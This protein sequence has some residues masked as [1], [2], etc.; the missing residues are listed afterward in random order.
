M[1]NQLHSGGGRFA[2]DGELENI[3]EQ[4]SYKASVVSQ[5]RTLTHEQIDNL[6]LSENLNEVQEQV[7]EELFG[8]TRAKL[9]GAGAKLGAQAGN[10][11][12]KVTTGA[13]NL[14]AKAGQMA[15]NVGNA[16]MG[17]QDQLAPVADAGNAEAQQ[18]DPQAAANAAKLQSI[19]PQLVKTL[20]KANQSLAGDLEALGL[21]FQ[22]IAQVDPE[23]AKSIKYA[24]GWITKAIQDLNSASQGVQQQA[25]PQQ[26][27]PAQQAPAMQYNSGAAM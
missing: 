22:T 2:R 16:A 7:I 25:D 11:A 21:N 9:A 19:M 18:A 23:A 20:N 12:N 1:N 5:F 15:S 6:L 3:Y 14:G 17:N 4:L 13:K 24:A 27:A 26:Q 10:I 8:K